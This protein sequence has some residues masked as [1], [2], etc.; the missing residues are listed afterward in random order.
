VIREAIICAHHHSIRARPYRNSAVADES[1]AGR[2]VH[3]AADV[4]LGASDMCLGLV[5]ERV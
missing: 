3:R 5:S 1:D 2:V 4:F